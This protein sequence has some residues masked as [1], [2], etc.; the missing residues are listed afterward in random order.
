M[1]LSGQAA[2]VV[3]PDISV[4]FVGTKQASRKAVNTSEAACMACGHPQLLQTP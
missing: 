1:G 4:R 3:A 2:E